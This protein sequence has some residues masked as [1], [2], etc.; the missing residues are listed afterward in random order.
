MGP[1][2]VGTGGKKRRTKIL[3]LKRDV[4]VMVKKSEN[5]FKIIKNSKS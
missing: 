4:K 3:I 5:I 2:L 1:P